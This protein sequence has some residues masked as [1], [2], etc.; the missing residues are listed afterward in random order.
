M[1]KLGAPPTPSSCPRLKGSP[2]LLGH[3][4]S[5]HRGPPGHFC[6]TRPL[7]SHTAAA[8]HTL[9]HPQLLTN[10]A[11]LPFMSMVQ[12]QAQGYPGFQWPKKDSSS[13]HPALAHLSLKLVKE[14]GLKSLH[15][16][17]STYPSHFIK[18]KRSP[19][20]MLDLLPCLGSLPRA[21]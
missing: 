16:W 14:L 11:P 10:P 12:G 7:G 1:G 3:Q 20:E 19:K 6:R 13:P 18:G 5:G 4:F 8:P 9:S 17:A 15:G 21:F 2:S